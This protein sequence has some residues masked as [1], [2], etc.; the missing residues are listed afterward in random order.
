MRQF[1]RWILRSCRFLRSNAMRPVC[2]YLLLSLVPTVAIAREPPDARQ[3]PDLVKKLADANPQ[4]RGDAA[5]GLR[6]IG[7]EA[8]PA[9]LALLSMLDDNETYASYGGST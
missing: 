5:D 7:P 9:V 1:V 8:K 3:I 6:S 4:V 2:L